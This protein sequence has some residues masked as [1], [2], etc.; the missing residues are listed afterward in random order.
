MVGAGPGEVHISPPILLVVVVGVIIVLIIQQHTLFTCLNNTMLRIRQ[1]HCQEVGWVEKVIIVHIT[2]QRMDNYKN[3][4][5]IHII[6]ITIN[7]NK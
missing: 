7:N 2:F 5:I 3:G 1:H 6:T 4:I